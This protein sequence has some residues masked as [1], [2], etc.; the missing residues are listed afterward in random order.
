MGGSV[1]LGAQ[2]KHPVINQ[3]AVSGTDLAVSD[4]RSHDLVSEMFMSMP[5]EPGRFWLS[6][7]Y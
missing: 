4:P 2:V 3:R 6:R 1:T 7:L 5:L